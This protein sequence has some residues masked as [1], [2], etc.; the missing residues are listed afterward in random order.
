MNKYPGTAFVVQ[1]VY[2]ILTDFEN[3]AGCTQTKV[4]ESSNWTSIVNS[5][6]EKRANFCKGLD[7]KQLFSA[8]Y[9]MYAITLNEMKAVLKVSAQA[10]QSGA[11]NKTS[12][13]SMA[14]DDF[15]KVK[16]HKT[17]L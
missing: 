9:G 3:L 13:E 11:V 12:V 6:E 4:G 2:K 17:H 8:V 7:G 1:Q 15:Q 14:Q 10:G 16:R 5:T